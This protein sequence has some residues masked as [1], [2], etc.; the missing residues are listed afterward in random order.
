MD[1]LVS[2]SWGRFGQVRREI[3]KIVKQFGDPEPK[4]EKTRVPGITLLH[5]SLDGRDVIQKC[6]AFFQ[7]NPSEFEFAIKWVPVD[8]WCETSLEAIKKVIDE[9]VKNNIAENETWGIQ[10]EK[11][12]W[13][14][15][16]TKE[17][18]EYLA[19]GIAQKVNL[20]NP[21]K[22]IHVDVL[23]AKT[24]I[25]LLKPEEIFSTGARIT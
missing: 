4:I 10:V 11:R 7:E 3:E 24:A 25:S 22:I 18:V 5:T 19:K 2:S 17:I 6:K 21:D 12:R 15:Y 14:K 23:G 1:I 8:F 13:E 16:H 9:Q 20:D